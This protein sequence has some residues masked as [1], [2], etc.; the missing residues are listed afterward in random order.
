MPFLKAGIKRQEQEEKKLLSE[1]MPMDCQQKNKQ[2]TLPLPFIGNTQADRHSG[3][4]RDK[5]LSYEH[6]VGSLYEKKG[7][8]VEYNGKENW[9]NDYGIDLICHDDRHTEVVQCKCYSVGSISRNDIYQF[10]GA[11][12]YYAACHMQEVVSSAFWT[13]IDIGK[14]TSAFD[15]AVNLGIILHTCCKFPESE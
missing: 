6:Y 3:S 14:D 13:T 11:S 12:R 7:Y 5:G 10:F 1:I 4:T 8:T 9:G 15:V 2:L